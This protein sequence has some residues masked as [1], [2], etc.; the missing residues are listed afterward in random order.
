MEL[1]DADYG[2]GD[3]VDVHD[4]STGAWEED[5]VRRTS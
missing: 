5:V 1:N 2:C 3:S 4:G